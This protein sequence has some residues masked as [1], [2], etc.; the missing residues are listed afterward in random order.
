MEGSPVP[1]AA[2]VMGEPEI[3]A[4]V[5]VLRSGHFVQG[6]EVARF[7]QE[8]AA[9]VQ[10]RECIAVSSGTA[11]L[12]VTLLA[13]KIGP[14]DEVIVPSFSFVATA[15][16]VRLAGA[17]PVLADIDPLTYCLDP[18]AA[19]SAITPR[20]SALL[21]VHLYGHPAPVDRLT[22]LAARHGLALIEDACQAHGAILHNRPVGTFGTGCFSFYPTKNMHSIEGGMI[23]T[24]DPALARAARLLRNHGMVER[25]RHEVVGANWRMSDVAAAV[26]RVQLR[27]L[28]S[29]TARRRTHAAALTA[30]LKDS[31][32]LLPQQTPGAAH[33][34]HQYTVRIPSDRTVRRAVI[35]HFAAHGIATEVYYPTPIHRLAPYADWRARHRPSLEQSE[36]A[37]DQVLSLPVHPG[38]SARALGRVIEAGRGWA[39]ARHTS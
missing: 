26:G 6:P 23:T 8:Y 30:G 29:S 1:I 16:A 28:G 9:L 18:E 20:T 11:A 36:R 14:G 24:N 4:V 34:W 32:L 7:E 19:A 22:A 38:L 12:V 2:P 5:R 27:R 3:A 35:E 21:P 17:T 25:Y 15:N 31:G 37:S 13:H 39:A 10:G 33:V